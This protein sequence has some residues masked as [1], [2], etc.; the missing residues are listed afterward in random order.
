MKAVILVGG[1][2]TR[3]RPLTLNTPKAMMPVLNKPFLEYVIRRLARHKVTDIVLA[4]SHLAQPIEDHFGNGNR[5]GVRLEYTAEETALGTAGAVKNAEEYLEGE[6]CLVL[7]GDIFT[8]LDLTAMMDFH[9]R[10]R[11]LAT[12]ALTP[13]EDPTIYGLVETDDYGRI[14]RFLEKPRWEDVTT[15]MINAGTYMLES[16][17]LSYIPPQT[18]F[19]F[20]RQVFPY[21]LERSEPIYAF[22]S[23]CY[24]MDIGTPEKYRRLNFDLLEG[25]SNQYQPDTTTNI[26]IGEYSE[27]HPTAIVTAPVVIGDSCSIGKNT[28][29]TGPLVI[30]NGS[31]ITN[32]SVVENSI[33]WQNVSV[34]EDTNVRQSIIA[35]GC[36]IGAGSLIT[37]SIVPDNV[38]VATGY[39][40]I[41]CSDIQPGASIG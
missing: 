4:I 19:S 8:D 34:E 37:D 27:C 28:R 17:V 41:N 10:S 38:T 3:L 15:N 14:T 26:S 12:I 2:G 33:I 23:L 32:S 22:P 6:A 29:L 11:A 40:M 36:I 13:V 9:R 35:N 24:W 18:N 16:Q 7:N 39:R 20:E 31:N 30:G 1:L 5:F 21:L 25:R